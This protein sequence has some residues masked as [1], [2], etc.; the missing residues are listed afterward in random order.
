MEEKLT[1]ITKPMRA[2]YQG[3][4]DSM[5]EKADKLMNHPGEAVDVH[6]SKSCADKDKQRL[7]KKGGCAKDLPKFAMGGVAKI[8]HEEATPQGLPRTF[9]KKSLKDVL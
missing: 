6:Y 3:R 8:R 1:K 9:K 4:K 7:Y 5:R 2:G